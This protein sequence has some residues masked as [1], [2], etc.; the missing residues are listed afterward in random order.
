MVALFALAATWGHYREVGASPP[1]DPLALRTTATWSVFARWSFLVIE[2]GV[3]TVQWPGLVLGL[4]VTCVVAF[5][6]WAW[7]RPRGRRARA[8]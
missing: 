1:D 7:W 2:N 3:A 6:V 4:T 5:G 8:A